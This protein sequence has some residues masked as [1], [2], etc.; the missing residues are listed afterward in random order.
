[1]SDKDASD[2]ED[3]DENQ[4]AEDLAI[5]ESMDIDNDYNVW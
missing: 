5:L 4:I 1:M 2:T 3:I